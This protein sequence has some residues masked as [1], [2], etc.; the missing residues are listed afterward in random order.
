MSLN[1]VQDGISV[2]LVLYVCLIDKVF[3]SYRCLSDVLSI[4]CNYSS[5]FGDLYFV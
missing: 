1:M 3:C 2:G 5:C 4:A